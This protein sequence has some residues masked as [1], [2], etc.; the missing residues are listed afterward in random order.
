MFFFCLFWWKYKLRALQFFKFF[1]FRIACTV[2]HFFECAVFSIF[3]FFLCEPNCLFKLVALKCFKIEQLYDRVRGRLKWQ[4]VNTLPVTPSFTFSLVGPE[5]I[6]VC[7][8]LHMGHSLYLQ[9]FT[10]QF[11]WMVKHILK[12]LFSRSKTKDVLSI[13]FLIKYNN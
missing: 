3:Y 10:S 8:V 4:K 2:L 9:Q 11:T 7:N 5:F 6:Y 12:T 1:N 13:C